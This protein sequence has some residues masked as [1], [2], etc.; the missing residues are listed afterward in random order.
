[1]NV[2]DGFWK[3]VVTKDNIIRH[4]EENGILTMS[5]QEF[6]IDE[7]ALAKLQMVKITNRV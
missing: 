7:G 3:A 4:D 5:L 2:G 6:L 1:M